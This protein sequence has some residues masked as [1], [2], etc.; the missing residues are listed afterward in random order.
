[1]ENPRSG[2]SASCK[3]RR[4]RTCGAKARG[5]CLSWIPRYAVGGLAVGEPHETTCEMTAEVTALL[6]K[7]RPRYLMASAG[8]NR[9]PIMWLAG[10]T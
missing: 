1:M 2:N 4:F 3:A 10:S 6:P 8:R 9:S 5:N 7:E